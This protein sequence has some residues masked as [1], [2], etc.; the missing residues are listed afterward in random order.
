MLVCPA[1]IVKEAEGRRDAGSGNH[2]LVDEEY[3]IR[4]EARDL[5]AR[6]SPKQ[7]L[8]TNHRKL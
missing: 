1:A 6:T 2:Q 5:G 8:H 4:L 3:A 7:Q